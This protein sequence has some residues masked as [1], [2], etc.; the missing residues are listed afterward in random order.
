MSILMYDITS[1]LWRCWT[2]PGTLIPFPE[3]YVL[4]IF[5]CFL[6]LPPLRNYDVRNDH[7]WTTFF[8][9][10]VALYWCFGLFLFVSLCLCVSLENF[11]TAQWDQV[12]EHRQPRSAPSVAHYLLSDYKIEA[13][14]VRHLLS[15]S[16][17]LVCLNGG[18]IVH[19]KSSQPMLSRAV[20]DNQ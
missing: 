20:W 2:S 9:C 19:R 6:N 5:F 17:P 4:G 12:W 1:F 7:F 16:A 14:L 3:K 18:V 15:H 8:A 10:R 13:W 11:W